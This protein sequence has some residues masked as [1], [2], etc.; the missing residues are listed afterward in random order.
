MK[1]RMAIWLVTL[2]A[3]AIGSLLAFFSVQPAQIRHSGMEK[4]SEQ[5]FSGNPFSGNPSPTVVEPDLVRVTGILSNTNFQLVL[6]ALQQRT[7]VQELAEPHVT[8][9]Y[10]GNANSAPPVIMNGHVK[11]RITTYNAGAINRT[12][13]DM[14]FTLPVTNR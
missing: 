5:T 11:P 10:R 8:T 6:R 1:R 2:M 4:V 13:Y 3:V 7:G 14:S 12:Y 9:Y